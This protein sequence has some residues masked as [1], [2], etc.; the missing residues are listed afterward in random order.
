MSSKAVLVT[1]AAGFIGFHVSQRLLSEGHDVVGVD[2]INDYYDPSL[3]L[4]R[5][6]LLKSNSRFSFEK[7][8]LADRGKA[9]ALFDRCRFAKVIHL[10]AQAGV[11]YSIQ[12]P[13][14]YVDANM[15]GFLN[16]LEGCR[17]NGCQHLVYASSSSVYGANSKLPFS[18]ED[19]VD[20]P[21][22]L[23]AASKRANEL[24]AHS[25]SHLYR[26]PTTGLRFFTV[27]G[28]WGRPDMAMFIFA[29]SILAGE[30]IRLFN[31]GR[32]RRDFTYVDDVSQGVVRL[33]D[34][35][36]QGLQNWNSD[37]PDRATSSA[38]WKIYNIGNNKPE[39]LTHVISLLEK[40]LGKV[41]VREMLPMQP[42]DVEATYAEVKDLER[43]IG[44]RPATPIEEGVA[45][46]VKWYRD[47]YRI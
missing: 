46:F 14:A 30:P 6:D 32:M 41:A 19:G 2:S 34:R 11:R 42:G 16:I 18:T 22:S 35:A 17:H 3:K 5:L 8:D 44:F 45:R 24:M 37:K 1:G 28:P 38:P 39:E 26:L 25:Y 27:Y 4:A 40:E 29:R 9:K 47:Y 12:D 20:H 33:I 43:D 10:A 21:I 7:L 23:Y 13:H 36:P 31:H 15:Q